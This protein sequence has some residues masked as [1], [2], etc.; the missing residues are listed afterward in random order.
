MSIAT[1]TTHILILP[2]PAW[3]DILVRSEILQFG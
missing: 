3:V 1:D 2:I